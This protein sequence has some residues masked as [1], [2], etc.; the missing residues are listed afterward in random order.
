MNQRIHS[1]SEGSQLFLHPTDLRVMTLLHY[2]VSSIDD[3][4]QSRICGLHDLLA[5]RTIVQECGLTRFTN[6][7]TAAPPSQIHY[8]TFKP[9]LLHGDPTIPKLFYLLSDVFSHTFWLNE[10][11]DCMLRSPS[12]TNYWA[13]PGLDPI[14]PSS[15]SSNFIVN[16]SLEIKLELEIHL[17][18]SVSL[19]DLKLIVLVSVSYKIGLRTLNVAYGSL[20][21]LALLLVNIQNSSYRCINIAFDYQLFFRTIAMEIKVEFSFGF[22]HFAEHDLP[23]DDSIFNFL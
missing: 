14:K 18:S 19:L 23:F 2:A 4:S 20:E 15:L 6:Y 1:T 7:I 21:L 16:A 13:Q 9:E 5:A 22:L 10:C 12:V 17:V 3:S 11:D 8:V